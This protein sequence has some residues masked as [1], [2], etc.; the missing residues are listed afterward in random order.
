MK[1]GQSAAFLKALRK[2]HGLGEFSSSRSKKARAR[3]SRA[4]ASSR[5]RK[6]TRSSVTRTVKRSASAFLNFVG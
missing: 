5:V 3:T 2:K 6:K 4:R 1:R